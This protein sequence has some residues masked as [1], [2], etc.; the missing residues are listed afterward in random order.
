[1]SPAGAWYLEAEARFPELVERFRE[2]G[3]VDGGGPY[4]VWHILWEVFADAYG[5]PRDDDRIRR[6]YGYCDWCLG[7]PPGSSADDD[8]GSCIAVCFFEMIPTLPPALEDMPR[9]WTRADVMATKAILSH[10]VGEEGFARIIER[11]DRRSG[12]ADGT[13]GGKEG[14]VRL[15]G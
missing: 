15:K 8:L 2:G 10:L 3:E 4:A 13:S 14:S 6:V 1:M 7:Q 11:F 9:W 12:P 5:D